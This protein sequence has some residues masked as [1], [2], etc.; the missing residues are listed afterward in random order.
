M[1]VQT[2]QKA[3]DIVMAMLDQDEGLDDIDELN[4]AIWRMQCAACGAMDLHYTA[5][6]PAAMCVYCKRGP[7][8]GHEDTCPRYTADGHVYRGDFLRAAG[9]GIVACGLKNKTEA[10]C[11]I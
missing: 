6:C 3:A 4:A 5:V 7:G 1:H 2:A 11:T 10:P 9:C 8:K